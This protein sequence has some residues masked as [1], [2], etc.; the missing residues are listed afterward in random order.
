MFNNVLLT[1]SHRGAVN[2]G[3]AAAIIYVPVCFFE[4]TENTQSAAGVYSELYSCWTVA[5]VNIS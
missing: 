1:K 5:K 3:G 2:R 4:N